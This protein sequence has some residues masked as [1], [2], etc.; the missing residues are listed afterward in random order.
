MNEILEKI[1]EVKEELN[2]SIASYQ[3]A[4]EKNNKELETNLQERVEELVEK[5]STLAD[6]LETAEKERK[7]IELAISRTGNDGKGSKHGF[8]SEKEL[9]SAFRQSLSGR[10]VPGDVQTRIMAENIKHF[11]PHLDD[12]VAELQA[13]T[14]L[15][16]S[17]PDGGV[18]CPA[19]L[20]NQVKT[21]MY[22]TSPIRSVANVVDTMSKEYIVPFEAAEMAAGWIA[23]TGARSTTD[24]VKLGSVTIPTHEGY[25]RP[26]VSLQVLEDS[27]INLDRFLGVKVGERLARLQNNAY[28]TGNGVGKP[29]GILDYPE[30]TS[31]FESGKLQT[32]DTA[33][34]SV[35]ADDLIGIQSEL[36]SGYDNNAKFSMSKKFFAIVAKL[37]D[38]NNNYLINPRLLMEGTRPQVLGKP[39]VMFNDMPKDET[40]GGKVVVYG[41]FRE[42]YT[43]V[44]RIGIT[45]IR[46]Q[47]TEPGFMKIYFRTRTGGAVS[48]YEALKVLKMK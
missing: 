39:V 3:A 48:N 26:V 45:A 13:K 35:A 43:I 20:A 25:A 4:S 46:D 42:G 28:I 7:E 17:S 5:Q 22:E 37:K 36:N 47:V 31:N 29:R 8:Q 15:V 12:E 34:A 23:E 38:D 1:K 11:L 24:T 41:D 6:K 18:V 32:V 16:G 30:T 40:S 21:R 33:G 27:A 44:D 14:M 19:E 10:Q 2:S 9:K